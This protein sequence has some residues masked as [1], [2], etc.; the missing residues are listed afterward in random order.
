M[1]FFKLLR[2]S[3]L[4]VCVAAAA[5][6]A[7]AQDA[8]P[9]SGKTG[10]PG[11][12]LD[13]IVVTASGSPVQ[14]E[15]TPKN[16]TVITS[17]DIEQATSASL[18]DL[19]T[20]E[21]N[22][23]LRSVSG[24]DKNAVVDV[25]GMGDTSVSNV[26]VMVDGYRMNSASMSGPDLS[27]IPLDQV[28][29][30]EI[31]RGSGAVVYGQGAV[32]G[33]INII[34][35]KGKKKPGAKA[36]CSYGSWDSLEMGA[37]G[38][39]KIDKWAFAANASYSDS[40]GYR[41]NG[42]L[43]KRN[44]GLNLGYDVTDYLTITAKGS[45]HADDYGLPG[46]LSL[47]EAND[48]DLRRTTKNPNSNG[49]AEDSLIVAGLELDLSKFGSVKLHRGYRFRDDSYVMGYTPLKTIAEQ[50]DAIEEDTKDFKL[51]WEKEFKTG[52]L[53]HRILAGTDHFY[54]EYVRQ[55]PSRDLRENSDSES[56]GFFGSGSFSLPWDL[57]V[58]LGCRSD[59]RDVRLRT[60]RRQT[61][62]SLKRWVNGDLIKKEHSNQAWE[63][64][65]VYSPVPAYSLFLNC[66]TSFRTPNL[67]EY[68]RASND[69]DGQE[70]L[71][72]DAGARIKIKTIA[73]ITAA[74]FRITNS[75]EIYFDQGLQVNKNYEHDT[76]R[77]GLELEFKAYPLDSL[78]LWGG[79]TYMIAEF[80]KM[81]ANIPLVPEHKAN[82]GAELSPVKPLTAALA[83]TTV[84]SMY[85]GND[86]INTRY[87]KLDAYTVVDAKF[88]YKYWKV[89]AFAGV[90]NIFDEMYATSAYSETVYPMPGRSFYGGV[91]WKL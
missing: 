42:Y 52:D 14:I 46:P 2:L 38:S 22:V 83:A 43:R 62:G 5:F 28:E 87:E 67:D 59:S 30:I 69:L 89:E 8:E 80:D 90:N 19:L 82:L 63:G 75:D 57:A 48:S 65:I 16:V 24:N 10:T 41:D 78:Y 71:H 47:A 66:A 44:A 34:T 70:G 6:P 55:E 39:G 49:E 37:S 91:Q 85:D 60:D 77:Q 45:H 21:A 31:V 23:N 74:L 72:L 68:A 11:F 50:T 61:F 27:S 17:R 84:G 53:K 88:T 81:D 4:V 18:A 64:G 12:E 13:E 51:Q 40:D 26:V 79:Y 56:L 29:R 33:V 86:Q 1:D 7:Q 35:K 32:G 58:T 25:R 9:D 36:F 54:S 20:R 3:A 76:V 15:D 73:E